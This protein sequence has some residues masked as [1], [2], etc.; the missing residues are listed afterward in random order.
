MGS[1]QHDRQH[2][3]D[4]EQAR[5]LDRVSEVPAPPSLLPTVLQ[6]LGLDGSLPSSLPLSTLLAGLNAA[7]WYWRAKALH[8]LA[9]EGQNVPLEPLL[10]AL[11]DEHGTVR[12]AAIEALSTQGSRIP[13]DWLLPAL[14]DPEWTV[15]EA[16]VFAL[17]HLGEHAPVAPLLNALHDQDATVRAAAR[18]VLQH[19]Y[20]H[21]ASATLPVSEV[22][23]ENVVEPAHPELHEARATEQQYTIKN[24]FRSLFPSGKRSIQYRGTNMQKIVS[25]NYYH[26]EPPASKRHTHSTRAHGIGRNVAIGFAVIVVLANIVAWTVIAQKLHPSYPTR[27]GGNPNVTTQIV[28]PTH[29]PT[30]KPISKNIGKTLYSYQCQMDSIHSLAWFPNG[31]RIASTCSDAEAWDAT[32]GKNVF[33]YEGNVNSSVLSV[34]VSPDGKHIAAASQNEPVW[35]TDDGV[36]L[37]TYQPAMAGTAQANPKAIL[38]GGN[39]IY[40]SAWSPDGTMIASSIDGNGYGYNVQVWKASTGTHLFTLQSK[41]VTNASDYIS[42]VVWSPDGKRIA[43]TIDQ[44]VQIW[45]VA[46]KHLLFTYPAGS[47]AWSPDGRYI[48]STNGDGTVQV[49]NAKTRQTIYVYKGQAREQGGVNTLAW[50]PDGT[51]I[52]SGGKDIHIWDATTGKNVFI[53]K[54][55]GNGQYTSVNIIKWSPDGTMIASAASNGMN[56]GIGKVWIAD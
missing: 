50:S 4:E 51:R 28:A 42:Q 49:W 37:T 54:A 34:I 15:R 29:A 8:L 5:S 22:H 46:T 17:E 43:F 32:T 39:M 55:Y 10:Q 41:P 25:D 31:K 12:I 30:K 24:F 35:D 45:D 36:L 23:P 11:Q 3:S 33:T 19:T 13:V 47:F 56:G 53:Y 20:P 21:L 52:A 2:N 14:D 6:R 1:T 16:G 40:D 26:V 9:Q 7:E 27:T 18:S 48:A 38:G 44:T